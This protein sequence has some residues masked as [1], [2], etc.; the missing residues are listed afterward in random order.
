MPLGRTSQRCFE[1]HYRS[2]SL[3]RSGQIFAWLGTPASVIAWLFTVCALR[4]THRIQLVWRGVAIIRVA[5]VQHFL[6]HRLVAVHTLHLIERAF[7]IIQ[8]QPRHAIQNALHRFR[9]RALYIAI[10]DT[11]NESAVVPARIRPGKK[12]GACATNVQIAGGA[13]GKT[14]TCGHKRISKIPSF[15]Q[16]IHK[17]CVRVYG[18]GERGVARLRLALW[19]S[20]LQTDFCWSYI[21]SSLAFP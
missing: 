2:N 4:F 11:Q 5:L 10:F 19:V 9:C 18:P 17:V 20:F 3:R 14:S 12:C 15:P 1:A 8:T 13:G 21:E 6:K 7:V 16:T